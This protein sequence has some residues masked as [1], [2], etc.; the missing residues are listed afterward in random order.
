MAQRHAS[1]KVCLGCGQ[2]TTRTSPKGD[3]PFPDYCSSDCKR[4]VRNSRARQMRRQRRDTPRPCYVC[5]ISFVSPG[6][7]RKKCDACS[8]KQFTHLGICPVCDE[9]FLG[10]QDQASCSKSCASILK[11]TVRQP[12]VWAPPKGHG[13]RARALRFGGEIG[14]VDRLVV[15]DRDGWLCGLCACPINRA[16]QWPDPGSV[17]L[18]HIVPL[19]RGGGHTYLNVQAAHLLCNIRKRDG[20]AA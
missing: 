18:D 2:A 9:V 10:R 19:A 3:G 1:A 6:H 7:L 13:H 14:R 8:L 15:F 4:A 20:R 17:S 12:T 11:A 5:G 16:L